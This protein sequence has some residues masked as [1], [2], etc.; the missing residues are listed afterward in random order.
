ME[1]SP[2]NPSPWRYVDPK[3]SFDCFKT[4]SNEDKACL[5]KEA[6]AGGCFPNGKEAFGREFHT[7]LRWVQSDHPRAILWWHWLDENRDPEILDRDEYVVKLWKTIEA[8][9]HPNRLAKTQVS[10]TTAW[11]FY[12]RHFFNWFLNRY[13]TVDARR[14][15]NGS[16]LNRYVHLPVSLLALAAV[17]WFFGWGCQTRCE[18]LVA[19]LAIVLVF[20]AG[21]LASG[22][23]PAYYLQ[24]LIPRMAVTTGLGYL[25]LFSASGLVAAIYH[26]PLPAIWQIIISL[27]LALFV[28]IYMIQVIQRRVVPRLNLWQACKRSFHL[29][30]L[31]L[32]YSAIGLLI[33]APV[34]FTSTFLDGKPG[35]TI[36]PAS[37]AALLLTAT[38]VLAIGVALQ[39]VWDDKPVTEPF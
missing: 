9:N 36:P 35:N 8:P 30:S 1:T 18:W 11:S 22:I 3:G 23:Q 5:A 7:W 27:A 12:Q 32:A 24:A 38:I 28:L 39:L 16:W 20:V 10:E 17:V 2:F 25:F 33:S 15:F 31:G 19:A 21:N 6:L 14:V 4:I 37:S 29:L 13:N 34:L 26:N